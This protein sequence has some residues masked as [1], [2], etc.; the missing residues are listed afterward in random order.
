M[1]VI[2]LYRT[3]SEA[4]EPFARMLIEQG[5]DDARLV[6]DW[7]I[8]RAGYELALSEY[9]GERAPHES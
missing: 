4:L 6:S 5:L 7:Q 8:Y 3:T 9:R 1:D 2:E